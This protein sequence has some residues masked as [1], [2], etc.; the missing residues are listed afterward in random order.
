MESRGDDAR[1][2]LVDLRRTTALEREPNGVPR[3]PLPVGS[4]TTHDFLRVEHEAETAREYCLDVVVA[5]GD[6]NSEERGKRARAVKVGG[7]DPYRVE[8]RHGRD[9]TEV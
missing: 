4:E 9:S 5:L 3:R 6:L 7:N 2:D 8:I 1:V